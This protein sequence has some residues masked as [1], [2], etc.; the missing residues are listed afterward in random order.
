[1]A[2]KFGTY[3]VVN[4]LGASRTNVHEYIV[5]L[6][7][8]YAD[9]YGLQ[10][11]PLTAAEEKIAFLEQQNKRLTEELN[12]VVM[13]KELNQAQNVQLKIKLDEVI[14]ELNALRARVTIPG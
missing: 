14:K 2:D 8:K 9:D 4:E 10:S 3:R 12:L 1:L 13:F 11:N 7:A 5:G 6:L